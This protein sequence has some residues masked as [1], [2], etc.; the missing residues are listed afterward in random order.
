MKKGKISSYQ[1]FW[2]STNM[3]ISTII[4]LI[5]KIIIEDGR[6]YAWIV[7]IVSGSTI[8]VI[9]YLILKVGCNFSNRNIIADLKDILGP[10][11]GTIL[12]IP[13][14]LLVLHTTSLMMLQGVEFVTFVMPN[15]S[16]VGFWI[17]IGLLASYLS[18]KGIE[19]I[20]RMAQFGII[21]I[22]MAI[23]TILMLNLL[24]MNKEWLKPFAI[25]YKKVIAASLTPAHWFLIIPN[26]SLI[27][28]PYFTDNKRTIRASLLG[29]LVVQ[30]M[31][32]I[33]FISAL[34]TLG[35]DLTSALKFPFYTLSTLSLTGLETIIFV[36]KT[37][38]I[39]SRPA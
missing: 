37:V 25:N 7:P 11:I 38:S 4:L 33:L 28:K 29:N 20:A 31:I 13:Y 9:H 15:K 5:P 39:A 14:I 21:V 2:L 34:T 23:I 26:L 35:V 16:I 1:Y 17:A 19:T 22:S 32:V 30:I 10:F 24:S 27:F 12:L 36:V 8:A 6:E 3:I 18:Y